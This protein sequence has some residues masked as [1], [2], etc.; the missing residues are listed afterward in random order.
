MKD[1]QRFCRTERDKGTADNAEK[2]PK[3]KERG[4]TIPAYFDFAQHRRWIARSQM[5]N[6]EVRHF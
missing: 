4:T 5:K 1:V 3:R 6:D 2:T